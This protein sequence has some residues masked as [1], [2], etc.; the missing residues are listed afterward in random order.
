MWKN[1]G[2]PSFPWK[3]KRESAAGHLSESNDV[4]SRDLG[5]NK[6]YLKILLV[7]T[8]PFRS[9]H[10]SLFVSVGNQVG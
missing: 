1:N 10:G 6:R 7:A 2:N 5:G 3:L 8:Q 9:R 4:L